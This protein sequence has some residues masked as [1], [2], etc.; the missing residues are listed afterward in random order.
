MGGTYI[1]SVID[2]TMLDYRQHDRLVVSGMKR[3]KGSI[4]AGCEPIGNLC[5]WRTVGNLCKV[6]KDS[7]F[8][9]RC[10]VERRQLF[11]DEVIVAH[12]PSLVVQL[13]GRC[14]IGLKRTGAEGSSEVPRHHVDG[15]GGVGRQNVPVPWTSDFDRRCILKGRY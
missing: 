4:C 9:G 13:L 10:L 11:Y 15:K 5:G 12:Y 1:D 3:D 2:P 14:H 7:W 6:H 8:G